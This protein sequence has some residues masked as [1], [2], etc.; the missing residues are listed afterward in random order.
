MRLFLATEAA[1]AQERFQI[2][3][4][5]R[6]APRLVRA[7]GSRHVG[8]VAQAVREH[9]RVL[10]RLAGALAGE[11]RHRV[12]AVAEE[13]NAAVRPALERLARHDVGP[14][15]RVR[16]RRG[17]HLVPRR[18]PVP[19]ALEQEAVRVVRELLG[20]CLAHER[21]P[22]QPVA[23]RVAPEAQ[24]RRPDLD[25]DGR[26]D[27]RDARDR[28]LA[29]EQAGRAELVGAMELTPQ[30]RVQPVGADDDVGVAGLVA[31]VPAE[32]DGIL[33][34]RVEQDAEQVRPPD[35]D[36]R[37]AR[38][39]APS[40]P[41]RRS[42]GRRP[43]ACASRAARSSRRPPAPRRR[44]RSARA[45]ASRSARDGARRRRGSAPDRPP[46]RRPRRR[47]LPAGAP[48]PP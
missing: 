38:P 25:E 20:L 17:D 44:A 33:A 43:A 26:R 7:Q 21:E 47:G 35:A 39:S 24:P 3:T 31:D 16:R 8:L 13:G 19:G 6:Q 32:A 2:S 22:V 23:E 28:A 1:A 48:R 30:R 4:R 46:A 14:G 11:R 18:R 34:D 45:R 42:R 15:D 29:D 27:R 40:P 5:A 9:D 41:G 10:D 36:R 12:R 37:R